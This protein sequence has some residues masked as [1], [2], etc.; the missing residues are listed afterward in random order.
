[1]FT[2]NNSNGN[3]DIQNFTVLWMKINKCRSE[4]ANLKSVLFKPCHCCWRRSKV[5]KHWRFI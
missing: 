2:L 4:A 1:M 3:A 5:H